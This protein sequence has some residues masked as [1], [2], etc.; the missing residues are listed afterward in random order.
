MLGNAEESQQKWSRMFLSFGPYLTTSRIFKFLPAKLPFINLFHPMLIFS[1]KAY[2]L[3]LK[4]KKILSSSKDFHVGEIQ[5]DG[6]IGPWTSISS[7]PDREWTELSILFSRTI[8]LKVLS[9][10]FK[11]I[12]MYHETCKLNKEETFYPH[13]LILI[14]QH[15]L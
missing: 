5:L 12:R 11:S 14:K 3:N 6:K 10:F 13:P 2:F 1:M 7:T 15:H 4:P 8:I 9:F